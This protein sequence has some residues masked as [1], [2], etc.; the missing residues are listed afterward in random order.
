M[1]VP[2][3]SRCILIG[4]MFLALIAFGCASKQSPK[5]EV[6]Q[7]SPATSKPEATP[8][9]PSD[10]MTKAVA[11]ARKLGTATDKPVITTPSG[12]RYIEV[13]PGQGA[14]IKSGQTAVV[15]YTGWLTDG[16][17]FDSSV[18]R[19]TPFS[20]QVGAGGVIKGW[21][22]GVVGMKPGGVRKLIIP[23]QLG[24]GE[25]GR[26]PIPPNAILIFEVKLLKV[27]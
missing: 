3:I 4:A 21:D 9:A 16:T 11:E 5:A 25:P 6:G 27:Q 18:R 17:E 19:G 24:Y 22:E 2:S 12:L 14:A 10:E 8:A 15:H 20:F 7:P 13:K 23:P 26:G 1:F